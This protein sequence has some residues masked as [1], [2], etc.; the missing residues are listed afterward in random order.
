MLSIIGLHDYLKIATKESDVFLDKKQLFDDSIKT[1]I[2]NLKNYNIYYW[3][4]YCQPKSVFNIC[5]IHYQMQHISFLDTLY[6]ITGKSCFSDFSKKLLLQ[7][8]NP[9]FRILSLITKLLFS[10]L[11]KYGRL[12]KIK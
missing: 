10:N 3:S 7:F 12:Y 11:F 5:S 6:F 2:N 8:Y 4:T 1:L 9:L